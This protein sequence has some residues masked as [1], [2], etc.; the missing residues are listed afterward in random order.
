[1]TLWNDFL[2]LF[3]P[4]LCRLCHAPLIEGEAHIC[5]HCLFGLPFTHYEQKA[6]NPAALLFAGKIQVMRAAALLRYEKKGNVQQLIHYLKY[7]GNKELGYY[8][9]RLAAWKI[10]QTPWYDTVDLLIPVPLH[11][12]KKKQRGYNQAE[13][14]AKGMASVLHIPVDTKSLQRCTQTGTQTRKSVYERWINVQEVFRLASPEN[15]A[16]KHILLIDDVITTGATIGACAQ[17]VFQAREVRVSI[18]S[19]AIAER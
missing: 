17:A 1:M 5:L 3:F 2:H 12:R 14:I 13:W 10:R 15:L 7:K 19:L 9:G 8:L 4:D 6:E 11:P 18:F 16:G